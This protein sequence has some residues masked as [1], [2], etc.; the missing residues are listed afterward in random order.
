MRYRYR[1][2]TSDAT[3][4]RLGRAA[5]KCRRRDEE[6]D[7]RRFSGIQL[8]DAGTVAW[9]DGIK[10]ESFSKILAAEA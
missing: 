7:E 4:G 1:Y 8:R 3:G 5:E 9:Q 2:H 10:S 6:K